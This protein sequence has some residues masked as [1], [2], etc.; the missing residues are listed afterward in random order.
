MP[1]PDGR[2]TILE[3]RSAETR[4]LILDAARDVLEQHG[5]GAFSIGKVA[6]VAGISP[7]NLTY[8]Y[9]TRPTL[10]IALAEDLRDNHVAAF[11]AHCASVDLRAADWA[12]QLLGWLLDDAVDADTVRLIPELWSVGNAI[13]EAATAIR[14]L[15]DAPI[16]L[17]IRAFGHDPEDAATEPLR[18]AIL[19][20]A[21]AL[22]GTTPLFGFRDDEDRWRSVRAALIALHAP[23]IE[24]AH[25]DLVVAAGSPAA[26][27]D[28]AG[29]VIDTSD[30]LRIA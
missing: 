25:D 23:A 16:E 21:C 24:R 7:G 17:L 4:R 15:Y 14:S 30:V 19:A 5:H 28:A 22:E 3:R 20:F 2:P 10:L 1:R 26:A 29:T 18:L 8:H 9:R 6:E 12:E 27:D 11:E 13:P